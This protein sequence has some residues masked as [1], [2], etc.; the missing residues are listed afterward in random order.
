MI[1]LYVADVKSPKT[2]GLQGPK[3]LDQQWS[4][5]FPSNS[6]TWDSQLI[7]VSL[8]YHLMYMWKYHTGLSLM[9]KLLWLSWTFCS[10]K[11]CVSRLISV[12]VSPPFAP[13]ASRKLFLQLTYLPYLIR[14]LPFQLLLPPTD[15]TTS[16]PTPRSVWESICHQG[17][18]SEPWKLKW[19]C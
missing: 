16:I 19:K 10:S 7:I 2:I 12:Y 17:E 9:Y 1:T 6:N 11:F 4:L 14:F 3:A 13:K 5:K 8:Y 15:H 18:V